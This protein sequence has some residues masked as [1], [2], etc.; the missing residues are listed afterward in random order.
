MNPF[1]I[2]MTRLSPLW[3]SREVLDVGDALELLG[4]DELLDR[5]DD[6]LGADVVGQLGDDDALAAGRDV[7]DAGGGAHAE[8]A[9]ARGVR[10]ADALEPDDL[11]AGRQVGA[12]D[13]P[14][15]VVEVGRRVGDQ[16]PQRLHDL[17]Q[18]VRRDVGGH[19]DGDAAGAVDEQV[20]QGGRQHDGLGLAA[21]V[22]GLEVDGVLVDRRR[23]RLG[24]RVHAD[25]GVA[26]RGGRIVL[27][28][29]VAVAVGEGEAQRPGLHEPHEGVVDRAVAVRVQATHD[30]ADGA[31]ALDVAAIAAQA[32]VVH[33][34]EDAPLHGLETVAGI[35]QGARVDHRVGVLEDS[36]IA[37]RRRRRCRRCAP[38]SPPREPACCCGPCLLSCITV[39][40][41]GPFSPVVTCGL[42]A[43]RRGPPDRLEA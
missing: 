20:G 34:V 1:L 30:L 31:R 19:A 15:D 6:L 18:V 25:L 43:P 8:R 7:L 3:R 28:A 32:H 10:V 38:R 22:V 39:V 5:L 12:G 24:G 27:R 2:S 33:R 40:Q 36:S 23:H 13:E 37:S 16:V 29:E 41:P 26:H 11:A 42:L 4:L 35:G 9:V 21:V 17:D 14:H